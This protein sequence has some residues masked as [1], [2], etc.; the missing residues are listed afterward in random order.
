MLNEEMLLLALNDTDDALLERTRKALGYKLREKKR[1]AGKI[2][3]IVLIA[4][5]LSALLIG[6]AYAAGLVG[7]G[8]MR[9]GSLFGMKMLSM[10]GLSDSPEGQAL[11][12][13]LSYYDAHRNELLAYVDATTS[14][15]EAKVFLDNCLWGRLGRKSATQSQVMDAYHAESE[16]LKAW[17]SRRMEWMRSHL[18]EL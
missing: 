5:V 8:N 1:S 6:A 2:V 17:I 12:E 10:E 18:E 15:L 11:S 16:K 9:A 13:W 4:A 7:L 3:R 14:L